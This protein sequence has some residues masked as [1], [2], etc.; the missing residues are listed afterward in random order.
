MLFYYSKTTLL[1]GAGGA[2][3][4]YF[5]DFGVILGGWRAIGSLLDLQAV[6]WRL[7]GW[8]WGAGGVK[9]VNYFLCIFV[10]Q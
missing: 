1:R 9:Y 2:G 6:I 7:G 5:S 4:T 10:Y 8:M 3:W